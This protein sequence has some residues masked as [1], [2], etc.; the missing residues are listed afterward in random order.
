MKYFPLVW[1]NLWRKKARTI[2]TLLSIVVAFLL[3]GVLKTVDYAFTHP[4][5]AT[6]ADKLI[7]SSKYS[8]TVSLPIADA[9]QIQTTPG[10]AT[11]TW[12]VW[13]GGYY[14]E[15]KNFVFALPIDVDS[16]LDLH[17]YEPYILDPGQLQAFRNTRTGALVDEDLAKKYGWKIGDK[18]PLHST[19]WSK[20][21]GSLDWTFDIVGTFLP[22]DPGLRSQLATSLLFHYDYFDE[23]RTFGKGTVGWFE[24]RVNDPNQSADIASRIDSQFANSSN[25]TKTAPAR[26]FAMSFIKQRGDITFI[27]RAVIDAVFFTLLFLT[28]NTMMQSVR[29][30]T[31]ELAVLKTLGFAGDKVLQLVL[32]ESLLLCLMAATVGLALAWA[33]LPVVQAG[34][35]GALLT[36]SAML[37]GF[38]YAVALALIVGALPALRALQLDVVDALA[39]RR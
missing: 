29:E 18:I 10:V 19:I 15:Q 7:T 13:F 5:G 12:F 31:P 3:F 25:E 38:V 1:A 8:L 9:Q 6:G 16:Y 11:V 33:L 35:Q 4:G 30:R 36:P 28:G 34:L 14:Q 23:G 17:K 32:A 21:D 39:E 37:P 24:E 22:Q 27:L 2:F 26:D 20:S